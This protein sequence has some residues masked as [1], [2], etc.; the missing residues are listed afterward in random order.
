MPSRTPV[1][2]TEDDWWDTTRG[3]GTILMFVLLATGPEPRHATRWGWLWVC[4]TGVGI[5]A[6]LLLS[7]SRRRTVVADPRRL[8]GGEGF[9]VLLVADALG[10][11]LLAPWRDLARRDEER[12]HYGT[13]RYVTRSA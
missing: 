3:L 8:T 1:F 4:A 11:A 12:F 2:T 7:G 13:A 6:Y 5:V 9:A 10:S